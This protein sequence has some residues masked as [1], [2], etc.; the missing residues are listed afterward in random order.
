L[1]VIQPVMPNARPAPAD[2]AQPDRKRGLAGLAND[3]RKARGKGPRDWADLARAVAELGAA[4]IT[5]RLV[6][7]RKLGI[8]GGGE[9]TPGQELTAV[10]VRL[11]DR[12]AYAVNVMSLRVPWRSDC[13]IRAVAARRWLA[14]GGVASRIRVGARHDEQ[15]VFMAHAW[16][17]V[18]ERIVTGGDPVPYGEFVRGARGRL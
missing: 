15:G 5:V 16:L 11:V 1:T 2:L 6:E 13:L 3:L 4:R 8:V 18:G 10:Q 17:T 14:A 9:D 7:P 12:V